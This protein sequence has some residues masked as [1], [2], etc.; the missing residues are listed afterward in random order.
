[1]F[2]DG[3]NSVQGDHRMEPL[4]GGDIPRSAPPELTG[5]KMMRETIVALAPFISLALACA[6]LVAATSLPSRPK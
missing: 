6:V 2:W 4:R 5:E 3:R 1:M